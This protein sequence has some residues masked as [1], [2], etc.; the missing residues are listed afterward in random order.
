M[1]RK[2][3]SWAHWVRLR[4]PFPS[5]SRGKANHGN[6]GRAWDSLSPLLV[7][8]KAIMGTWPCACDS[9]SPCL[10]RKRRSWDYSMRLRFPFPPAC[11][12][13]AIV[14]CPGNHGNTVCARGSAGLSGAPQGS[15]AWNRLSF[16]RQGERTITGTLV[17]GVVQDCLF[18]DRQREKGLRPPKSK[19]PSALA[20]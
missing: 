20:F 5:A 10:S 1:S 18:N 13:K 3:E 4:F 19:P 2:R 15:V 9:F 6:M 16:D 7:E 8:E 12:G 11:Q 14:G 17:W